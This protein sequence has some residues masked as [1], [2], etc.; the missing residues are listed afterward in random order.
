MFPEIGFPRV[1]CAHCLQ[2]NML[3]QCGGLARQDFIMYGC[4]RWSADPSAAGCDAVPAWGSHALPLQAAVLLSF[5]PRM[6]EETADDAAGYRAHAVHLCECRWADEPL[7]VGQQVH[8][9]LMCQAAA[10]CMRWP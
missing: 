2:S 4:A 7:S 9:M 1:V 6:A 5:S 10:V 3:C 8:L